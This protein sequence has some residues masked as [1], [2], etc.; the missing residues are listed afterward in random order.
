MKLGWTKNTKD[1]KVIVSYS[2]IVCQMG[3]K[4]GLSCMIQNVGD[5]L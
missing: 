3:I 5:S 4:V 2:S 1:S